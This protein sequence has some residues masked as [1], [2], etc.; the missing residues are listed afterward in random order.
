MNQNL[1]DISKQKEWAALKAE[2]LGDLLNETKRVAFICCSYDTSFESIEN[3][4][5]EKVHQ[6]VKTFGLNEKIV[7]SLWVVDDLPVETGF[8]RAVQKGFSAVSKK[9]VDESRLKLIKMSDISSMT[10]ALKGRA[11]LEGM[12]VALKNDPGLA[13]FVYINLNL[14]VDAQ[15]SAEG[16]MQVLCKDFDAAIGTRHPKEGGTAVGRGMV[17]NIKSWVFNALVRLF[18]EPIN[19]YYDTN[20]P[21]KVYNPAAAKLL[22]RQGVIQTVGMDCDWLMLLHLNGY[23]V[24]RF[25]IVW[26]QRLGSRVPWHMILPC[27]MDV[28]KIRKRWKMGKMNFIKNGR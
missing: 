5:I 7:W 17:G 28:L 21:M 2:M 19:F 24:Y 26:S 9:L 18:L 6:L 4:V 1:K 15:F 27:F 8:G 25:P 11:L 20:A 16:L 14:K 22:I 10:G 3:Q 12:S 23:E 13:A